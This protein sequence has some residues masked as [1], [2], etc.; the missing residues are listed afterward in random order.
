MR[1]N[2]KQFSTEQKI[3]DF[4]RLFQVVEDSHPLVGLKARVEGYDWVAHE[5]EL[6]AIVHEAKDNAEFARAIHLRQSGC[7]AGAGAH[8][9]S[10]SVAGRYMIILVT[11]ASPL[12]S[13]SDC[14]SKLSDN[15]S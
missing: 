10:P 5:D 7:S 12:I 11:Q 9:T 13:S 2:Q 1:E 6:R 4:E 15:R 14:T 3:A 8:L